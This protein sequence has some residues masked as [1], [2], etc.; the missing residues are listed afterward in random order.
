VHRAGMEKAETPIEILSEKVLKKSQ[1]E[2]WERDERVNIFREWDMN[3]RKWRKMV[4]NG[5][6]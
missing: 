3:E 1:L 2:G 4:S 5:D 6:I